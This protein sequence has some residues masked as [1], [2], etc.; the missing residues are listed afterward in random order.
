MVFSVCHPDGKTRIK[1]ATIARNRICR[2][3]LFIVHPSL[4]LS[5]YIT[6]IICKVFCIAKSG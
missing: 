6:A 1:I 3:I 4:N 5:K 2:K